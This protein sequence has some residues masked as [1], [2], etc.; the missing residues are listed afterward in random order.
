V[1]PLVFLLLD[2]GQYSGWHAVTWLLLHLLDTDP[3]AK[4]HM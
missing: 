3:G 1:Q 4:K 2:K